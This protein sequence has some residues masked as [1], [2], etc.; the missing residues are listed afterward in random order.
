M[1]TYLALAALATYRL[2]RMIAAEGGPFDVFL[3]FRTWAYERGGWIEK[4]SQCIYCIS[5]WVAWP[6]AALV[7]FK[8]WRVFAL[9]ALATSGGAV[10][11]KRV[12]DLLG[13]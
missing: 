10:V 4:G 5:F 9:F 13:D 6:V 7:P 2:S 1:M 12:L 3:S 11:I 8:R